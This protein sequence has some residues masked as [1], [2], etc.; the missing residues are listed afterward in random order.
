MNTACRRTRS[1]PDAPAVLRP[2]GAGHRHR[3][4]R[5]RCSA[6]AASPRQRPARDPKTG[7]LPGC[8]TSRRR[9]SASSTCTSPAGRRSST[10]S[11]TSRRSRS[12]TARRLPDS[13]RKGQR[14]TGMTSGQTLFPVAPSMFKFA[15]HGKSG[16]WVSE[17]LPHT[18]KIVDDIARHQDR[19]TPRRSTTTRR[20]RSSRPAASSRAG[21]AWARG[22]ATAWAARTRTCRRSW[23]CSRRR[24]AINDRP[25][26]VLAAVGERLP[27]VAATRACG[28]APA[29]TRCCISSNP[30]GIDA[31]DAPRR[32]STRSAALNQMQLDGVRRPGDR[33]AHRAVRDGVPHADV[34]CRS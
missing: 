13:I 3:R 5:R 10:C 4:A 2:H 26:A 12:T 11:T 16:T 6:R 22:S 15:Q 33:D 25:A 19:C 9:R 29:A 7:G 23:C 14:I 28:S 31:A 27:A 18:A 24:S 30:P 21:R 17:L 34:A 1:P 32:C 8:R 20:S